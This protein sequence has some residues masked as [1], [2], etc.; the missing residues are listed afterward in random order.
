MVK[1][2]QNK[3]SKRENGVD[4][5]K[6][7][8]SSH[9]K[10]SSKNSDKSFQWNEVDNEELDDVLKSVKKPRK[11]RSKSDSSL[12]G[13]NNRP[14]SYDQWDE[15]ILSNNQQ[16]G[17]NK[18]TSS[19]RHPT[20]EED[21]DLALPSYGRN[22]KDFEEEFEENIALMAIESE[23]KRKVS[24]VSPK[25]SD[26]KKNDSD[27]PNNVSVSKKN[28]S[29]EKENHSDATKKNS[30]NGSQKSSPLKVSQ[31]DDSQPKSSSQKSSSV[32]KTTEKIQTK[33]A[34]ANDCRNVKSSVTDAQRDKP[35]SVSK[36]KKSSKA[37]YVSA[38]SRSFGSPDVSQF[39]ET[40]VETKDEVL[41]N[42]P[43]ELSKLKKLQKKEQERIEDS[44]HYLEERK[45][46]CELGNQVV[47]KLRSFNYPTKH[48]KKELQND[49]LLSTELLTLM[50]NSFLADW[51]GFP[52]YLA[53]SKSIEITNPNI[54][55]IAESAVP[56]KKNAVAEK[57]SKE[58]SIQMNSAT[59]LAE[60]QKAFSAF[61]ENRE[62]PNAFRFPA[63]LAP[64][65]ISLSATS[66][67][68]Y[69]YG[70]IQLQNCISAVLSDTQTSLS[71]FSFQENVQRNASTTNKRTNKEKKSDSI[72]QSQPTNK[73][74]KKS[75]DSTSVEPEI[76]SAPK[77]GKKSPKSRPS[78]SEKTSIA[79]EKADYN[80]MIQ[81]NISTTIEPTFKSESNLNSEIKKS[82]PFSS[83][84]NLSLSPLM[85]E[86][87]HAA[88]YEKP[89]PIQEGTI[90][91]LMAGV[92]LMGQA[93]TGTGKTA[94]F[95]IPII[96][97]VETC[98]PGDQPV[99]LIVVPT[100][101][102]A[103][104]VRDEAIKLSP[105]RDVIT[106]ACYGGKPIAD[107]IHKLSRGVDII[108]GTPGRI[109]DLAKRSAFSLKQLRWVVLDEAD[110]MLDIGFRPDIERI[111]K[112]TPTTRQTM[113]FSATLDSSVVQLAQKYMKNPEQYDFSDQHITAETIEQY[114]ITVDQDR[115][116]DALFAL[117]EAEQPQQAI[118]FCRTKRNVNRIGKLLSDVI[119]SVAAIHGDLQ[120]S[121]RDKIMKDF[122]EGKTKYLVATDVVGRG[123]DISGI[124]HIINY[125]IPK[126]C[127]DYVHRVGRTGRMGRE[128][129]A[130][131]LVTVQE[132]IEL[133]R[134]EKR[135]NQLLKRAELKGF[136]A[137][138]K[139][140]ENN[141]SNNNIDRIR[142]PKP[143]FGKPI[144]RFRRAL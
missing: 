112:L 136:E 38:P 125:D 79:S 116:F 21:D 104:Q 142:T 7:K 44:E 120:Q 99:A 137:Y 5:P 15:E 144:H 27:K 59:P 130:F 96:E 114:Y 121:Q 29:G 26:T 3:D 55:P 74:K 90:A 4:P 119:D 135:I 75:I 40:K 14:S 85:L 94:A 97:Q 39:I 42:A 22:L 81:S 129:V 8:K 131:T 117:I 102:L 110:R 143:V 43:F 18:L 34:A 49:Q 78:F 103:V 118:I 122:R 140:I 13:T 6:I 32:R 33:A 111:L 53:K 86:A 80:E 91:R 62:L 84:G 73:G 35:Q 12:S 46:V 1:D 101:E 57:A 87:L 92:D 64:T 124:S 113:L 141:S 106:V 60:M 70:N 67:G 108:V 41:H 28:R 89:T 58:D 69:S 9:S 83:F 77:P 76:H 82:P 16:N 88:D 128:G 20:D 126:F 56:E 31:T 54:S 132:G 95:L 71:D 66:N 30:S 61:Q 98:E 23:T 19:S 17:N 36:G 47:E 134:I 139:P 68:I 72:T 133:T 52:Q 51:P 123:I 127:D 107:Q 65:E 25:N 45:K 37:G 138:S 50:I 2:L 48:L 10:R 24:S 115:K 11:R 63:S 100:R 109:L 105:N 93:K